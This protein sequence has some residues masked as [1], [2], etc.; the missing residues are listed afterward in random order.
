[1]SI[2]AAKNREKIEPLL[3]RL[4]VDLDV[5]T[6]ADLDTLEKFGLGDVVPGT[7]VIDEKGQ[8]ITRVMGEARN[9][10]VRTP[11]DWLLQGRAGPA[12]QPILKRY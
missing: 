5:W 4:D 1:V 11:L 6:V 9:E 7:M 8:V 2:D 10:D 3:H 12:P